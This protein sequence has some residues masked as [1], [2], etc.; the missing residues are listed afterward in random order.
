MAI[1]SSHLDRILPQVGNHGYP[2][3]S[4]IQRP[5]THFEEADSE[6]IHVHFVSVEETTASR[7]SRTGTARSGRRI[8]QFRRDVKS[9]ADFAR[10]GLFSGSYTADIARITA[11]SKQCYLIGADK[12]E[13]DK[14]R[15]VN[16]SITDS[17]SPPTPS[18]Y[19]AY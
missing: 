10:E 6:G 5:V 18:P 2:F 4:R 19:G 7:G 13:L 14:A 8:H 17:I 16:N 12:F 1:L 9:R 3:H 11:K 15:T